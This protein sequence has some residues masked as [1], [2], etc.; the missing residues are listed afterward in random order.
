MLETTILKTLRPIILFITLLFFIHSPLSI[1]PQLFPHPP[2]TFSI[3]CFPPSFNPFPLHFFMY[4]PSMLSFI[5]PPLFHEFPLYSFMYSPSIIIWIP[6]LFLHP[7][8][9]HYFIHSPSILSL[10]YFFPF[11]SSSILHS[12]NFSFYP[13]LSFS[14]TS[15]PSLIHLP[16]PTSILPSMYLSMNLTIN[17]CI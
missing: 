16:I 2:T 1:L 12:L 5:P 13:P 9:L 8:P 3:T 7:F 14:F 10:F 4:S 11:I 6:P 17:L 15:P